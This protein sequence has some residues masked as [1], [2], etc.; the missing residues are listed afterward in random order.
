[1]K[2]E[3]KENGR[4]TRKG[5]KMQFPTYAVLQICLNMHS[6]QAKL[7]KNLPI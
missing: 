2:G 1:M 3:E 5:K 4:N 7:E 6:F